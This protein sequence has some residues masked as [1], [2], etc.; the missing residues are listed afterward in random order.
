VIL[1]FFIVKFFIVIDININIF[2]GYRCRS[3]V[4]KNEERFVITTFKITEYFLWF[5]DKIYDIIT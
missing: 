5:I 2:Q 1:I 3:G 4:L